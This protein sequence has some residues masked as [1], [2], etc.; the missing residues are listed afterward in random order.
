MC[1]FAHLEFVSGSNETII[2]IGKFGIGAAFLTFALSPL[3]AIYIYKFN[4][5]EDLIKHPGLL[6]KGP[7][8]IPERNIWMMVPIFIF[9]A[10]AAFLFQVI[11]LF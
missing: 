10:H 2:D 1:G 11:R 3:L 5:A 9:L 6:S 7:T 8:A 4:G